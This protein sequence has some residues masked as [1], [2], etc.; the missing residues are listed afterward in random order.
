PGDHLVRQRPAQ[1][2]AL[3]PQVVGELEIRGEAVRHA[4]Q[5]VVRSQTEAFAYPGIVRG[6][7]PA[8][9]VVEDELAQR[10]HGV[11]VRAP[12]SGT[13]EALPGAQLQVEGGRFDLAV[14][15]VVDLRALPGLVRAL[16]VGEPGVAVDPE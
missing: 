2:E 1:Y 10:A 11:V 6:G 13:Q 3:Q 12:E 8:G 5:P 4:H 15:R 14:A 9:R 16:V 7:L